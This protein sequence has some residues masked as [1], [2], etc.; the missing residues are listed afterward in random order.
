MHPFYKRLGQRIREQRHAKGLT[1]QELAE[2]AGLTTAFLSYLEN[3]TRKGSLD[4]YL[5]LG[6]TLGLEPEA[7]FGSDNGARTASAGRSGENLLSLEGLSAYD[8]RSVLSVVRSLRRK[9][10]KKKK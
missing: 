9:P 6:N 10:A 4:S 3:G 2:R 8:T 7:L 1:Q 5:V